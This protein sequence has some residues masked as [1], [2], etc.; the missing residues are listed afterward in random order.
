MRLP[1]ALNP[2][3][4]SWDRSSGFAL[5]IVL[6]SVVLLSLLATNITAFGRT[7]AQ[8]AAN[9][10]AAA[11][12]E[13]AADGGVHSAAFH[14]LD[15][16]NPWIADGREYII[17]VSGVKV[18]I[19]LTSEGGKVNPN[20]ASHELIYNLLKGSGANGSQASA[21][22]DAMIQWRFQTSQQQSSHGFS[23]LGGTAT[24]PAPGQRYRSAG[25]SYGPPGAPFEDL[26]E[27]NYV[28]GMT[29]ALFKVLIQHLSIYNDIDVDPAFADQTVVEALEQLSKLT[30]GVEQASFGF[31]LF[32]V[33]ARALTP[34]G[35]RA[36]RHAVLRLGRT[37]KEPSM[38]V[39][40]W[41]KD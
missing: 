28:L 19:T 16:A 35:G 20:I 36:T 23:A 30:P 40:T 21:I 31:D 34:D 8:L 17:E 18:V 13:A 2:P 10:R 38:R 9:V 11:Q 26:S 14:L 24:E 5:L 32:T 27:L 29:P 7:D 39:L 4:P 3:E 1:L 33:S 12:A 41:W 37:I 6:W 15:S 25:L 22:A